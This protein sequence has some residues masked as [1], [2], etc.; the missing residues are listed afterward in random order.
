MF[1]LLIDM[2]HFP[3]LGECWKRKEA[4]SMHSGMKS[5]GLWPVAMMTFLTGGLVNHVIVVPLLLGSAQRDAWLCVPLAILIAIPLAV[6]P[7]HRIMSA[8]NGQPIDQWLKQRMPAFLA[9]AIIAIFNIMLFFIGFGTLV[10]LIAWAS[11]SYLPKT[12]QI[13]T[14]L[15]FCFICAFAAANGLRTIA[16]VSCILLP[17]VVV[18]GDFVM[19][20][21]MPAK[22]YRYLLPILEDGMFPVFKGTLYSL[23]AFAEIILLLLIRHEMKRN[24]KRWQLIVLSI[25][26]ILLSLGPTMGAISLFGP[27]EA[28][29]MR[30]PAYSQWRM[31]KIGKYF[32][33]VDFFAVFQW[34]SG[35]LIRISLPIYLLTV[36]GPF[37]R[38]KRKWLNMLATVLMLAIPTLF[39][40]KRMQ[41]YQ[42]IMQEYFLL[43]WMVFIAVILLLWALSFRKVKSK[44]TPE[45]QGGYGH[46][47][48]QE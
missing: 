19:S 16:Y 4:D 23:S 2:H 44:S 47:S 8:M 3:S 43:S 5:I 21:N 6:I 37:R 34:L 46:A 31:V 28:A 17:I 40:L 15:V 38:I 36:Y 42:V 12:P 25:L 41:W 35:A 14:T 13:V 48:A 22:D 29:M 39:F 26:V 32:E 20:A 11:Y 18:L 30:Y 10:H 1:C 33:H 7:L 24:F 9:A 45:D 27:H